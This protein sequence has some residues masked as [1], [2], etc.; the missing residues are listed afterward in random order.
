MCEIGNLDLGSISVQTLHN[1]NYKP[2]TNKMRESHGVGLS[3]SGHARRASVGRREAGE[4]ARVH[5]ELPE[6]RT[7][8]VPLEA[9]KLDVLLSHRALGD[10]SLR[11]VN[12]VAEPL[13]RPER[14]L[15]LQIDGF[16]VCWY[17]HGTRKRV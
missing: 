17:I 9:R 10:D 2:I 13:L 5:E 14:H 4:S 7:P 8:V 3:S 1:N 6:H 16:G 11:V 12:K 15:L